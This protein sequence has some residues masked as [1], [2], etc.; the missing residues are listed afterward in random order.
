MNEF[1]E[2]MHELIEIY[3]NKENK[4][5]IEDF[6]YYAFETNVPCGD[7][8]SVYLKTEEDKITDAS[9]LGKGCIISQVSGSLFT[10]HIIGK[11]I[12]EIEKMSEEDIKKILDIELSPTRIKCATLCLRTTRKALEKRFLLNIL[13]SENGKI[14]A[15]IDKNIKGKVFENEKVKLDLTSKFYDGKEA[16]FK[17][18][19][20]ALKEF[21][22]ANIVG[23]DIVN[24]LKEM[25]LV[26]EENVREIGGCKFI[27]LYIID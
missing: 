4:R 23:N 16:T 5:K 2:K 9:F 11:D 24:V 1:M 22:T 19:K 12:K 15:I 21:Y 6:D 8:I 17:E 20:Y 7:E 13:S 27:H 26:H 14:V 3:K 10:K 25:N 18:I